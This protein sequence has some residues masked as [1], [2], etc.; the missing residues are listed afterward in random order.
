MVAR[1]IGAFLFLSALLL[2]GFGTFVHAQSAVEYEVVAR[3][4]PDK[5][6]TSATQFELVIDISGGRNPNVT[7][8]KL[9]DLANVTILN[10]RPQTSQS[11]SIVNGQMSSNFRLSYL[12]KGGQIGPA[13]IS[14]ISVTVDGKV[15]NTE[16]LRFQI[17]PAPQIPRGASGRAGSGKESVFATARLSKDEI[18]EGE[19]VV[20]TFEIYSTLTITRPPTIT[21]APSFTQFRAARLTDN[22]ASSGSRA[23]LDGR[24]YIVLPAAHQLLIPLTSGELEIEPYEFQVTV[25]SRRSAFDLL[26]RGSNVRIQT[27]PKVVTVKPLPAAPAGFGGAVGEFRFKAALDRGESSVNDAVAL[28]VVVEGLGALQAVEPPPWDAPASVKV[29]EPKSQLQTEI[30]DGELFSRKTWEWVLIPL[31]PGPI[32]LP[33][34]QFTYF[35]TQAGGYRTRQAEPLELAVA[36]G[37][38]LTNELGSPAEREVMSLDRVDIS[39]VR[40]LGDTPLRFAATPIYQRRWFLSLGIAPLFFVPFFVWLGRR[41]DLLRRDTALA[42][43]RRARKKALRSLT[44]VRKQMKDHEGAHF[45]EEVA[46]SLVSYVGDRFNRSPSGLTYDLAEELLAAQGVDEALRRRF[47]SCLETCDFARFVPASGESERRLE[48]LDDAVALIDELE[49]A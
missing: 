28:K 47:R 21:E 27:E 35:D 15:Y 46:R 22:S 29:Y 10:G 16:E 39:Y 6:I 14:P 43:N 37:D 33:D 12:A 36:E 19:S 44:T 45:H 32:D 34:L 5:G 49:K 26:S 1:R 31:A 30:R 11:T 41:R 7:D 38:G 2:S 18:W 4:L 25:S 40:G 3:I 13:R 17:Q 48:V 23:T 9:G 24:T 42:R 8:L 20:A